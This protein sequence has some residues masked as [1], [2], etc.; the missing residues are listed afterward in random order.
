VARGAGVAAGD[1]VI[2]ELAP[3]ARSAPTEGC[4]G[5]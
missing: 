5:T 3:E 4:L 2:A 1:E